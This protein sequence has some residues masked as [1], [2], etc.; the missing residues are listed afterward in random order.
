MALRSWISRAQLKSV[1]GWINND[2][3]PL[4][5]GRRTWNFLTFH[6]Y[7]LLVNCNITS[8]LTGSALI[9]LGLT[10]WQ[11]VIAIVVGNLLATVAVVLNSLPGAYYHVGF[12]VINRTVWGMWGSLFPVCNRI[13]LSLIWYGFNSWIGGECIYLILLSWDPNLEQHIPNHMPEDVGMTTASFV[14]YI[15]FCVISLPLI[16]TRPHRLQ[17]FFYVASSITI[18]FFIVLLIWALATMGPAGFGDTLSNNTAIPKTGGPNSVSWLMVYGVVSTIGSISAGILNQND[19]ARFATKPKFATWGQAL[20]FPFYG[21]LTPVVGIL[22]TAATQHRFGGT[23]IWDPPTLF[24]QLLTQNN[25]AGTRAAVFFTGLCLSVSQLGLNVPGN[26][27]SGGFDLAAVFPRYVSLRRGAYIT[28]VLS[29]A[30]NPWQLVNTATT[31]LTVLSSYSVF[32]GPMT[33]LMVSSYLLVHRQKINV[34]HLY[35]GDRTSIY[36]FTYGTNWRTIVAWL[37][38][39]GPSLPGFIA[40]VNTSVS[41]PPGATELYY[42]SYIYGFLASGLV[43]ALL[44]YMFPSPLQAQFTDQ[45]IPPADIRRMYHE[46]WDVTLFETTEILEGQPLDTIKVDHPKVLTEL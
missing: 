45:P 31:F 20:V 32:L 16:W 19:Y 13:F 8:Y 25:S 14:A 37:L 24:Q 3:R 23:A 6:N 5:S 35:I 44:H 12:P 7:W 40:A 15:V 18:I 9:P 43:L 42:I 39:V 21:T 33:G 4:E 41:V 28:A 34:D 30:V 29:I 36:W 22:V 46:K 17:N 38:G 11:A 26:A 10:W 1:S 2:I 27:L